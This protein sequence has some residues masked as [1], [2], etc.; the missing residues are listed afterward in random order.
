MIQRLKS[1]AAWA[2]VVAVIAIG[3]L[4][5]SILATSKGYHHRLYRAFFYPVVAARVTLGASSGED[6][7]LRLHEFVYLNVRT[8]RGAPVLDDSAADT[9][10]RGFGYCDPAVMIFIRLL[11]EINISGRMTFLRRD[12]GV[13]PH[14][15]SEVFLSDRWRVF[16]TLY[17]FVPRRPDG[18]LATAADLTTQSELL[19]L[20]RTKSEWYRNAQV[21]LTLGT[22]TSDLSDLLRSTLRVVA[23]SIPDWLVDR[24]Q[25]LYVLLPPPSYTTT[26]GTS[27]DDYSTPDGRQFFKARNFH[28]FLRTGEAESA[29]KELLRRYPESK[30]A[31]AALYNL[32]LL[33]LTQR[34]DPA[35]ALATLRILLEQHPDTGWASDA[36]YL[37]A[38]A[39]EESDDCYSAVRLH[40]GIS[41]SSANGMED[42]RARLSRLK[43]ANKGGLPRGAQG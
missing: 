20:S 35:S 9:L 19:D 43:C 2:V 1:K 39:Y 6:A 29:Y 34:R 38:R 5:V 30:H 27:F 32:G 24:L 15:V 33:E 13:S 14:T 11:E 42:A 31:D 4:G 37:L 41:T 17:G 18:H 26:A 10:I 12:D 28:V 40:Q 23:T 21:Y 16:D 22:K 3:A 25:D 7:V 36:R 8:P